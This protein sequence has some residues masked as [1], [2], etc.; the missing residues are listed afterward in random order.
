M[1][2]TDRHVINVAEWTA[3]CAGRNLGAAVRP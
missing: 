2:L 1:R 3:K